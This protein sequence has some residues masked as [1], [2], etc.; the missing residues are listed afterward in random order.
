[1]YTWGNGLIRCNGGHPLTDGRGNVRLTTDVSRNVTSS[2]APDAFGVASSTANTA[3]AYLWNGGA[4]YR[5]E[6]LAPLGLPLNYSFQKVGDRY[7]DPTMGCFL[8]RDTELGEKPYAYC[9]GDPVNCT[10]PSGHIV[11]AQTLAHAALIS[12][13]EEKPG[14]GMI[15]T[16]GHIQSG[17]N[18]VLGGAAA[19]ALR[20]DPA[21]MGLAKAL[22]L[23]GAGLGA[24]GG[25]YD[26]IGLGLN[27]GWFNTG[28]PGPNTYQPQ[29]LH[30]QDGG[31]LPTS[32]PAGT[33]HLF[34]R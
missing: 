32:G 8:T 34:E 25:L 14:Q 5:T 23:L 28:P 10:D 33:G 19:A 13:C 17:A 6:N 12:Q 31:R 21:D 26:L 7:Y 29:M 15:D 18:V 24:L 1:M 27:N 4:G 9:D 20:G 30:T 2:N 16:G 11:T 22:G 3:S